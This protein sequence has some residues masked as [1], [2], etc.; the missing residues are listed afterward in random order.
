MWAITLHHT[1]MVG[2]ITLL[3]AAVSSVV[4]SVLGHLLDE[5][6]PL[7]VVGELVAECQRVG[8]AVLTT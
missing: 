8:G 5:A 4:E 1:D 2:E 6:F 7:E 3:R